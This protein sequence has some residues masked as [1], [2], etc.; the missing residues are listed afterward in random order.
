MPSMRL[1]DEASAM[2]NVLFWMMRLQLQASSPSRSL[3]FVERI[4][5]SIGNGPL[6]ASSTVEASERIII[7]EV[8]QNARF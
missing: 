7:S 6:D 8:A 3:Q 4:A 1:D 2:E 5:L